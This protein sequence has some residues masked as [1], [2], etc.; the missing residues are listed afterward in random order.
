MCAI[1]VVDFEATVQGEKLKKSY[2]AKYAPE[3][4]RAEMLQEV[5]E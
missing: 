1:A 2:I 4:H 3:G 5:C